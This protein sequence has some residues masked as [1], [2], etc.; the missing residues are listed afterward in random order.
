MVLCH[1]IVSNHCSRFLKNGVYTSSLLDPKHK[2]DEDEFVAWLARTLFKDTRVFSTNTIWFFLGLVN[3]FERCYIPTSAHCTQYVYVIYTG[4]VVLFQG[5]MW[6]GFWLDRTHSQQNILVL[7]V[8]PAKYIKVVLARNFPTSHRS[9]LTTRVPY[10][11]TANNS[12]FLSLS[13][14]HG[15]SSIFSTFVRVVYSLAMFTEGAF[16]S[17]SST[18]SAF[19]RVTKCVCTRAYVPTYQH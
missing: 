12:P 5:E 4:V 19:C 15:V 7:Q 9:F 16:L 10:R 11:R 6:G 17:S 8:F 1:T 13:R 14:L 2:S 3:T 18:R